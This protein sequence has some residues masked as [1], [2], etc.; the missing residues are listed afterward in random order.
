M[1][2]ATP[3][4]APSSTLSRNRLLADSEVPV[5]GRHGKRLVVSNVE[6]AYH[7]QLGVRQILDGITFSLELGEKIAV[8]GRNGAGKSTLG[9]DYRRC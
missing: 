2:L 6:K 4:F 1:S 3:R 5:A 7:T 9:Q 8:L